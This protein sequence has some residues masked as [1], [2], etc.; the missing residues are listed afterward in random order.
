[1]LLLRLI[2][3]NFQDSPINLK[4]LFEELDRRMTVAAEKEALQQIAQEVARRQAFRLTFQ[5]GARYDPPRVKKGDSIPLADM[6]AIIKIEE[7]SKD[8]I[9]ASLI[10]EATPE[11]LTLGP[12]S[13]NYFD[14]P[15]ID[16][17]KLRDRRIS[18]M[19]LEN[20]GTTAKVRVIVFDSYLAPDRF[21]VKEMSQTLQDNVHDPPSAKKQAK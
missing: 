19:Q 7:V 17:T 10:S 4:P 2:A 21:D 3:L 6:A 13:V 9:R 12:F 11:K 14:M 8:M 20:D 15:L 18:L 5:N 16:N 1:M